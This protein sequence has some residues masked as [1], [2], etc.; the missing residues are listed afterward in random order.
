M[1]LIKLVFI[2]LQL[3]FI[4][5]GNKCSLDQKYC[6]STQTCIDKNITCI[7]RCNLCIKRQKGGENIACI[8][9]CDYDTTHLVGLCVD[10]NCEDTKVCPDNYIVQKIKCECSCIPENIVC[11]YNYLC[12]KITELSIP[13]DNI[14][15]YTVYEISI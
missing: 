1:N 12:P 11:D 13:N 10:Y 4:L 8:N 5:S 3:P 14:N 2:Y 15:G 6:P 7:D 9:D